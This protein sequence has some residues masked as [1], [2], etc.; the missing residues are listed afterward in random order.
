MLW[1]ESMGH[2]MN[3]ECQ[4]SLFLNGTYIGEMAH[5][6]PHAAGGDVSTD[7]LL[8]L[9]RNCHKTIDD[10]EKKMDSILRRWKEER[11]VELHT[12]FTRK[13]QSFEQLTTIVVPILK[14]NLEIFDSYG[15][16]NHKSADTG[17]HDLW[18]KFEGELISNN[19]QLKALLTTNKELLHCENRDI[20]QE[21]IVHNNEFIHTRNNLP[22][23]RVK[24]FPQNLNAIFG[25][26]RVSERLAPNVSALQNFIAHL[27]HDDRYI[28]LEL[29]PNQILI[30]SESGKEIKLHLNDR[31]RVQQIYRNNDCYSPQTTKLRLDG[32]VFVLQWLADRNIHYTFRRVGN[33]AEFILNDKY[34][35]FFCYEYCM[36][37][38]TM[39]DVPTSSDLLVVNLYNWNNGLFTKEAV[40]Y[41][42]EIGIQTMNQREFFVFVHKNLA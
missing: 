18:L 21:F 35:V 8:L 5:I 19:Q 2:C 31:P 24:L 4:V 7:N 39:Y 36:S 11:K 28:A 33:L 32:L 29:V 15:P 6:I 30:Y 34:N 22:T 13:Y 10:Q 9:C 3:P 37:L 14:R 17:R 41:A 27:V 25:V 26:E 23:S 12:R 16:G 38:A 20:V 42:S 40:E 1:A